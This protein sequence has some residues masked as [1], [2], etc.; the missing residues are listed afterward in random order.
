MSDTVDEPT[1]SYHLLATRCHQ[2]SIHQVLF[3]CFL[4]RLDATEDD[5]DDQRRLGLLLVLFSAP[6]YLKVGLRLTSD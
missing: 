3:T 5:E 4:M 1:K 2:R 6:G